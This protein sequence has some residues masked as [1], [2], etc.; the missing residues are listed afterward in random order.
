MPTGSADLD[1]LDA[2]IVSQ[3]QED[4]RR[5][6]TDIA[7]S[8][9]VTSGTIKNRYQRLVD[10]GVLAVQG[11]INPYRVGFRT[12]AIVLVRVR[13][14]RVEAVAE[15]M[16]QLPEVDFVAITTGE[17]DLDL[18]VSCRD[19]EDLLELIN[20][21]IHGIEDVEATKSTMILRV[22]KN[23]QSNIERLRDAERRRSGAAPPE[24]T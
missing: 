12:H 23:K 2:A 24:A 14:G 4:G 8:L 22:V 5:S 18:T 20:R 21:K 13:V 1:D 7:S 6:F 16:A 9:G 10:Q 15:A 17:Y 11:S 19:Q 3:L